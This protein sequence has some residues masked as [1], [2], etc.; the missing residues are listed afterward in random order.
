MALKQAEAI[1]VSIALA[2]A[3]SG[4]GSGGSGAI[5][6]GLSG[7]H[8][9]HASVYTEGLRHVSAFAWDGD[10]RLW[11]T[12][13]GATTHSGDGVYLV[14]RRGAAPR[15][16]VGA[17]GS[18]GCSSAPNASGTLQ[19]VDVAPRRKEGVAVAR[20]HESGLLYGHGGHPCPGG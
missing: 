15:K 6:A 20:K 4:C 11:A 5:G 14:D 18:R 13:S 2:S 9:Y 1:V 7:P 12:A 19:E 8:G 16:I 17:G 3:V 10:G